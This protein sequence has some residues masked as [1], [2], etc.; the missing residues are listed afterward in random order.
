MLHKIQ[1]KLTALGEVLNQWVVILLIWTH[2]TLV[3]NLFIS[4]ASARVGNTVL[5]HHTPQVF[6]DLK[7]VQSIELYWLF[8]VV[9][10]GKSTTMFQFTWHMIIIY[11]VKM[12]QW[13]L[14]SYIQNMVFNDGVLI[15]KTNLCV[16]HHLWE[17]LKGNLWLLPMRS[18]VL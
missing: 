13:W 16:G 2:L 5:P 18:S 11:H 10:H 7:L 12:L 15:H 1:A 6:F 8:L 17:W 14:Q 3:F 9:A 4:E